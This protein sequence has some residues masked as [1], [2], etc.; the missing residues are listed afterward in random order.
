MLFSIGLLMWY[1]SNFLE[2]DSEEYTWVDGM[3]VVGQIL[4]VVSAVNF[5]WKVML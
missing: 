3:F 2:T 4:M 5:T 1:I